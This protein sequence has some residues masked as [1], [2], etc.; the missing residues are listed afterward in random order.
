MTILMGFEWISR[1]AAAPEPGL[2][3]WTS[4]LLSFI[5]LNYCFCHV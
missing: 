3:W 1:A 5:R 2:G 4:C